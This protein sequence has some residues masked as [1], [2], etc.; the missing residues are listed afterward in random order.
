MN[1]PEIRKRIDE[2]N[3]KIHFSLQEFVLTDK[4]NKLIE[5]NTK[6]REECPHEFIGTFCRFCDMPIDFKEEN[7]D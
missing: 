6:L 4:I 5:E 1:G 7:H 3:R 2:N